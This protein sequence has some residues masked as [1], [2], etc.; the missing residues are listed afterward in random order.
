MSIM[1]KIKEI[2]EILLSAIS[3]KGCPGLELPVEPELPKPNGDIY[4]S[5]VGYLKTADGVRYADFHVND[6][7]GKFVFGNVDDKS[8]L[9]IKAVYELGDGRVKTWWEKQGYFD[10]KTG[11]VVT[12]FIDT[13]GK[14]LDIFKDELKWAD[15][16]T[17]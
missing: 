12:P 2:V 11:N 17:R 4:W 13:D 16:D 9:P 6:F 5:G 8:L 10:P 7:A 1:E 3:G 14:P 15:F